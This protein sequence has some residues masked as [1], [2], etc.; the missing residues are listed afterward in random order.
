MCKPCCIHYL[1][2]GD[3]SLAALHNIKL[4]GK[5]GTK[6]IPV[7][8]DFDYSGIVETFYAIPPSE[9]QIESVRER[10]YRGLNYSPKVFK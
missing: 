2:L 7:A 4:S 10:L 8:Y 6:F 5:N 9:L 1:N 3:F